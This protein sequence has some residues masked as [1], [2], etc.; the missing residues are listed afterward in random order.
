MTT[1]LEALRDLILDDAALAEA[2]DAVEDL[3][4]FADRAAEA[5]QAAGLAA[6]PAEIREAVRT[7]SIPAAERATA[8]T[9]W[10]PAEVSDLDGRLA[11]RW[12]WFGRRRLTA[13]F[14]ADELMMAAYRPLKRLV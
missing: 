2:L 7:A 9:G 4:A 12:R 5:V 11:V 10:L 6:Q 1:G 14:Y 8:P 13:P 3:D